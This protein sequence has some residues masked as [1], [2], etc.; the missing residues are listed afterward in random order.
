[1]GMFPF[2]RSRFAEVSQQLAHES[3]RAWGEDAG[4]RRNTTQQAG[5]G[6]LSAGVPGW[7]MWAPHLP[8]AKGT[9]EADTQPCGPHGQSQGTG[10][11]GLMAFLGDI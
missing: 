5:G 11:L 2:T 3:T 8:D 4:E 7:S 10:P 9:T 6:D 1:M